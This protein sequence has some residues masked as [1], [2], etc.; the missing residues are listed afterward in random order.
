MSPEAIEQ[1]V[2]RAL[3]A[4]APETDFASLDPERP[5]REQL[6]IDSY[7]F[8][9][10]MVQLSGRLGVEVP[11]RDYGEVATLRRLVEYLARHL[12]DARPS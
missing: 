2:R 9:R 1:A 6:D 11:E 12:P 3:A 10:L 4:V 5:L 7:D 8:L